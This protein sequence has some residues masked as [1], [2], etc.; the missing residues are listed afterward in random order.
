MSTTPLST[1]GPTSSLTA[2]SALRDGLRGAMQ[3][4]LW[5]LWI[6]ASLAC[7]L[8]A[9]MPA[10]NWLG[11]GLDHSVHAQAIASG[12][13]PVPLLD[14]V[15]SRNAPLGVIGGSATIAAILMLLLSPL[16][17]GA[18]IAA[19]R[20][21]ARPGFGDL[22]RGA[23][24]EYGPMLRML[25]WSVVP[26]GLAVLVMSVIIGVNEKA[27][28]HAILASEAATGRTI[29]FVVGGVLFVLAHA[30]LEAGRGWL[31][32]DG[33]LRSALKAWWR[34]VKLLC[35]RPV[36]VLLAWLATTLLGLALALLFV[37]LRQYASG[38]GVGG[39]LLALLLGCGIAAGLAWGRIARLYAMATLAGDMH[40]RR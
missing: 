40:A 37:F 17:A 13:A 23:I 4:R 28:E 31:A 1:N 14:L 21:Q 2:R 39:F 38:A 3:W 35:R 34:G 9:A 11:A 6:G 33:R 12:H 26:L 24:A 20:S 15:L 32:I 36:A 7:A 18:T 5:L 19:I 27:H 22:L 16:L 30:S 29:A 10:W 8:I 25:V